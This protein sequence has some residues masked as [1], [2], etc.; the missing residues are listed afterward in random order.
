MVDILPFNGLIYNKNKIKNISDVIS[1]PY[2]V[3]SPPLE[4]MLYNLDPHNIINLILPKGSSK[5]K[6]KNAN[7][8]LNNW[9]ENNILKFD[10]ERCFYIFEENFYM[11]SKRK[12]NLGFIGLT[13]IEP[14]NQ[15]KIIPHEQTILKPKQDRLNLLASCRTDFGVVYTLYNDNQ[16]KILNISKNTIQKKPFIDTPAGY[17]PSL[18]F[19]L[20]RISNISEI[21]EIIKIMRDKKLIIADGHHRYETSLAYKEECDSLKNK[22]N[23]SSSNPED[24]ILTLYIE[25]SQKDVF[26]YPNHRIIKFKNYPGIEYILKKLN[27]Y[28]NIEAEILKPYKYLEKKLFQSKSKGLKSFFI[29]SG[30]K[31]L[32]LI[33]LKLSVGDIYSN[34]KLAGGEYLNLDVNILHNLILEEIKTQFKIEK[35]DFTYSI[36]KAIENIDN[37]KFDI[38][39]LLN[40]PTINELER[41]CMSGHLMPHKSTY[42]YPKPC[43]GLVMYKFDR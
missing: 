5:E 11:G 28:F 3:I 35:I 43:T 40:A 10:N 32:Y 23:Q 15:L 22:G 17:D 7:K 4:K 12:K 18:R 36:D 34:A 25:S 27:I 2:D 20:W 21:K 9:I 42:F 19:K 29:Y 39:I 26:L 41:I 16:N 30:D 14:Y 33:T 13:K 6:Y 38:G 24:F 1:P 8:I 31:K 37:Q